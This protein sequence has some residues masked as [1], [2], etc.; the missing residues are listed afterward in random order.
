MSVNNNKNNSRVVPN[1]LNENSV[2][3]ERI[4]EQDNIRA[5][6]I[7]RL[8]FFTLWCAPVSKAF[9]GL[10]LEFAS[11]HFGSKADY[12]ERKK[13]QEREL[14][15]FIQELA[16]K[17]M[18]V[19]FY[20]NFLESSHSFWA[21]PTKRL[22]QESRLFVSIL[23]RGDAEILEFLKERGYVFQNPEFCKFAA[24]GGNLETFMFLKNQ[25]PPCYSDKLAEE[26][27][28][29]S[30]NLDLVKYIFKDR[31][32]SSIFI[33]AYAVGSGNQQLIDWLKT[34][35][36]PFSSVCV[37]LAISRNQKTILKSLLHEIDLNAASLARVGLSGDWDMFQLHLNR[38]SDVIYNT[39]PHAAEGGNWDI[40]NWCLRKLNKDIY[41][42]WRD[43]ATKACIGGNLNI[44]K[45]CVSL[46]DNMFPSLNL[47]TSKEKKQ[48]FSTDYFLE[49]AGCNGHVDIFKW[50]L[51]QDWLLTESYILEFAHK[52]HCQ[53][54]DLLLKKK[55]SS[56]EKFKNDSSLCDAAAQFGQLKLLQ[57]LRKNG[58]AWGTMTTKL[59][60][61]N[62]CLDVFVWIRS[63]SAPEGW[64]TSVP[65]EPCPWSPETEKKAQFL[66]IDLG[67]H[68]YS[69]QSSKK[70]KKN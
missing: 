70:Q 65:W 21:W 28:A 57:W 44:L 12:N 63:K 32:I 37:D 7:K 43:V 50:G 29:F 13:N 30:G 34:K 58:F 6:I 8:G 17:K 40:F 60:F 52:G 15:Y 26:A 56:L 45:Y 67:Q 39:L 36:A 11:K 10:Y 16:I 62:N 27:A 64:V 5:E 55:S 3:L 42:I 1:T 41:P 25:T 53:I 33:P 4:L 47:E 9:Y 51:E 18:L 69:N 48:Y 24:S 14:D 35:N 19:S 2:S 59:A 68:S 66:L 22:F 38:C 23:R 54:F 61:D 31:E 49:I 46:I 20:C